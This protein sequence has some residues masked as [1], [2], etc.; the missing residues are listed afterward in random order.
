MRFKG[1]QFLLTLI[2][3]TISGQGS[4]GVYTAGGKVY[5]CLEDMTCKVLLEVPE[6]I[7]IKVCNQ[8]WISGVKLNHY[9]VQNISSGLIF[10][11]TAP[12]GLSLSAHH[13]SVQGD[14]LQIVLGNF[15]G[16]V[17]FVQF[18]TV[19]LK[20]DSTLM[21]LSQKPIVYVKWLNESNFLFCNSD[22]QWGLVH[23]NKGPKV[24]GG[25]DWEILTKPRKKIFKFS[26]LK[27][28]KSCSFHDGVICG[29]D[30]ESKYEC[31]RLSGTKTVSKGTLSI[32]VDAV[33]KIGVFDIFARQ[34]EVYLK[35][36]IFKGNLVEIITNSQSLLGLARNN[37]VYFFD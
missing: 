22:N 27:D 18:D 31:V 1:L 32:P 28:L 3:V 17:Y 23:V 34:G 5:A 30:S 20:F 7:S 25:E 13:C 16:F 6:S 9:F 12:F 26:S 15:N 24:K 36:K 4:I 21:Q 14:K 37:R 35:E 19:N 2:I 8:D 10:K 11:Q 29:L 33:Y